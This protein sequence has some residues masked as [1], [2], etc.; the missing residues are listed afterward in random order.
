MPL[1]RHRRLPESVR[2]I[3]GDGYLDTVEW[4][5][6]TPN[7]HDWVDP[8]RRR[9]QRVRGYRRQAAL[10]HTC[11]S[12]TIPRLEDQPGCVVLQLFTWCARGQHRTHDRLLQLEVDRTR[13]AER[14]Q[15]R[16]AD[17]SLP[18]TRPFSCNCIKRQWHT[19]FVSNSGPLQNA[20]RRRTTIYERARLPRPQPAAQHHTSLSMF[21]TPSI[22][23]A[24]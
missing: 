11:S 1:P 6:V 10:T 19:A 15:S 17:A 23:N 14:R 4:Q 5:T 12:R 21:P 9:V 13:S 16:L 7:L 24:G 20:A 2:W 18:W 22:G 8:T 3:V